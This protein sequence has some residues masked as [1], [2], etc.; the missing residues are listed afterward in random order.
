MT[1]FA[2]SQTTRAHVNMNG[3]FISRGLQVM[4]D[5]P[6]DL[7][8]VCAVV[9]EAFTS[10][11][12]CEC[13]GS[14]E[15]FL[16]ITCDYQDSICGATGENCGRPLIGVSIVEGKMFSSTSCIRDYQRG[17]RRLMGETCISVTACEKAEDG[18]CECLA[19]Y[20]S[21][22][23]SSCSIC[24]G[25]A[26]I[27][28]DCTNVNAEALSEPCRKVD[29]DLDL[30]GGAGILGTFLPEMS[31]LCTGLERSLDNRVNCD[32]SQAK[33]GSYTIT[34]TT[35]E[36]DQVQEQS[37]S[38]LSSVDVVE[39]NVHS[40]TACADHPDPYGKTCTAF[41]F[42]EDDSKRLCS[43]L[44]TY[45]GQSC[46]LCQVCDGGEGVQVDCSNVFEGAAVQECQPVQQS[47]SFEFVPNFPF[48]ASEQK[49]VKSGSMTI[50]TTALPC[51][52]L[53]GFS[54]FF[55]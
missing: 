8:G 42:C 19:S 48:I 33:G 6:V 32:C 3:D 12:R 21:Q 2:S 4:T 51:V 36:N 13:F 15:R 28:F 17:S 43:C 52:I 25:G 39:G 9:Q 1:G 16:S 14:P 31:G 23:C 50:T 45:D 7:E 41:Q 26:G 34:C 35:D 24:E 22:V 40:V 11:V 37:V 38:V 27:S 18:I 10:D 44:A 5:G 54:F 30:G 20:E 53:Y 46:R 47:T 29:M 55:N 49:V